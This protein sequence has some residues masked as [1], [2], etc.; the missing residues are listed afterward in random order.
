MEVLIAESAR[1]IQERED[2][3][4]L[5][6][7]TEEQARCVEISLGRETAVRKRKGLK[8]VSQT[9]AFHKLRVFVL[10]PSDVGLLVI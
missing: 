8:A 9:G 6:I 10:K 7:H 2:H 1:R 5:L 3:A 4:A